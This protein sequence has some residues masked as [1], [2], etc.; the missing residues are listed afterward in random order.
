MVYESQKTLAHHGIQNQKWGVRNGPPYPLSRS[1]KSSAEKRAE[2]DSDSIKIDKG[3]TIHRIMPKEWVEKEKDYSG[4]AYASYRPEDVERYKQF[5][6]MFGDG[7]NYVDLTFKAK[8]VLISPSTKRR[9]DAFIELMDNNLD[10]RNEMIKATRN[11]FC[12]MPKSRLNRLDD[13]EQAKKAYDKFAYLLVTRRNLRDP[14]FKKLE[15]E[16]YS[17]V[18]DDADIKGKISSAPI[19]V[20]DRKKSLDVDSANIIGR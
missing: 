9:V 19:I 2:S 13:P 12:F 5:A 3:Q 14:Y 18:M 7:N 16:G 15:E 11:P 10:A 8:D 4:H 1:Q 17:M 20:F 6:R